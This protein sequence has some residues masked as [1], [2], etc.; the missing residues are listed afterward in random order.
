MHVFL[1][2]PWRGGEVARENFSIS[3][4]QM[5]A[6]AY[7]TKHPPL[8]GLGARRL[9]NLGSMGGVALW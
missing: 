6:A 9:L 1:G 5:A 7:I 4:W 8:L 2:G 3:K